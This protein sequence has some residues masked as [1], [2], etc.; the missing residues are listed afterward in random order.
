MDF[1]NKSLLSHRL[2]PLVHFDISKNPPKH[3]LGVLTAMAYLKSL[4]PLPTSPVSIAASDQTRGC[5]KLGFRVW[6]LWK[7]GFPTGDRLWGTKVSLWP[8]MALGSKGHRAHPSP[9][10][11]QA[12]CHGMHLRAVGLLPFD[13]CWPSFPYF[14]PSH[15][16]TARQA[17]SQ[18]VSPGSSLVTSPLPADALH[19]ICAEQFVC[20]ARLPSVCCLQKQ[21]GTVQEQ[22]EGNISVIFTGTLSS[23]ALWMWISVLNS[24]FIHGNLFI[25]FQEIV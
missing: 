9:P 8:S 22:S 11:W 24:L 21:N 25:Y 18:A 15:G 12:W 19:A 16:G 17:R 14:L 20:R 5:L 10:P 6:N 23:T 2:L 7:S 1:R 3:P 13:C 4:K